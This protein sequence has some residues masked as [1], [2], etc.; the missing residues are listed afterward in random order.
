MKYIKKAITNFIT[1]TQKVDFYDSLQD[2]IISKK[3]YCN[4]ILNSLINL[5]NCLNDF[6]IRINNLT[7]NLQNIEI[8]QDE[9]HIHNLIESLHKGILEKF[10][11]SSKTLNEINSHFLKYIDNLTEEMQIYKEFRSVY[12]NN[13]KKN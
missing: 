5:S 6:H 8:F 13:R 4:S 3:E 2:I 1:T 10:E 12:E 11:E 9:L 7:L